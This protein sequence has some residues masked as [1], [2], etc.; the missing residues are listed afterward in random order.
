MISSETRDKATRPVRPPLATY[1]VGSCPSYVPHI[2]VPF[3]VSCPRLL[4]V[5]TLFRKEHFSFLSCHKRHSCITEMLGISKA[6]LARLHVA[7]QLLARETRKLHG[8]R[9]TVENEGSEWR[10]TPAGTHSAAYGSPAAGTRSPLS[11]FPMAGLLNHCLRGSLVYRIR[12]QTFNDITAAFSLSTLQRCSRFFGK[13]SSISQ[14]YRTISELLRRNW[15]RA[16]LRLR[17]KHGLIVQKRSQEPCGY[18]NPNPG[19]LTKTVRR[20]CGARDREKVPFGIFGK[21]C[22]P[23]S[24]L[25]PKTGLLVIIRQ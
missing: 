14:S 5:Q 17:E 21:V 9:Q 2:F 20:T 22:P 7:G 8:L 10:E 1:C 3:W 6:D 16:L 18:K 12:A 24:P 23:T 25:H 13:T 11:N 19:G 4:L 15:V